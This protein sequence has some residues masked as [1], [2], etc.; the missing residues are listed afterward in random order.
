MDR[1]HFNVFAL[2]CPSRAAFD[3]IFSRWGILVLARLGDQP[4]RFGTL[5][6]SIEGISEKML[7]QTL[8]VLEEEGL[9]SRREWDEKPPR[10]EYTL[11][12]AGA[13]VAAGMTTVIH[14]LYEALEARA[15]GTNATPVC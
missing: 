2:Q 7:A 9:V 6:R 14:D 12:P 15:S 3:A 1:L 10:V 13:K 5:R 8:R 11:T 4:V